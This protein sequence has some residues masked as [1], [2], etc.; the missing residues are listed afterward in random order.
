MLNVI[1]EVSKYAM[2]AIMI[3]YTL[4]NFAAIKVKRLRTV[5]FFCGMQLAMVFFLLGLG[6][7]ILVLRTQDY[8]IALF[9]LLQFAA[10]FFYYKL[11]GKIYRRCSRVIISNTILLFGIGIMMLTRL[12]YDR[13]FKQFGIGMAA[14]ALSMLI[15]T[16]IKHFKKI[17]KLA[18]LY[19]ILGIGLLVLVWR[20]GNTSYG[21][22]LTLALGPIQLQ[23]SEFVKISFVFFTAAMFSKSR[24]F[25]QVVITTIVAAIHVGV[26][27]ASTDLGS[28]LVYFMSYLFMIYVAT[29]KIR[30]FAAGLGAGAVAAVGAYGIFDH[31][32]I[33][34]Q[35][36]QNPFSDY[37]NKGYQLAQ[38]LFAISSGGWFGLGLC[39][40]YPNSIPLARNDFIFSAI[41][42]EL[43][44]IFACCLVLIYLGFLIQLFRV[45]TRIEGIFYQIVG[46]GL[47]AMLGVQVFLHVGGVTAMIPSTG[48]TLPL[49]SY[50]GS[51]VLSTMI[52]IGIIQGLHITSDGM[53]AKQRAKKEEAQL[54]KGGESY[55]R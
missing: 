15:P 28:G 50:G 52:T 40:G 2:L 41:C 20:M 53:T 4:F 17:A 39:Q 34:V 21:A 38:S 19:A 54:L 26:L 51:S 35:M 11:F 13:A 24:T 27:V 7:L 31:V 18:W 8:T 10:Y 30:Y 3:I 6:Y 37:E 47:A 46:V 23:P 32:R 9:C 44:I 16:I 14:F 43:G 55:E 22:Q 42:E 5:R 49:I 12:D 25:K 48:I 1:T 45:S 33:R 29:H 36:W